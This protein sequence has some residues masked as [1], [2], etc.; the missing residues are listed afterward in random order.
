MAAL[1]DT[2]Q[3]A[4]IRLLDRVDSIE[5]AQRQRLNPSSQPHDYG[6]DKTPSDIKSEYDFDVIDNGTT[7]TLDAAVAAVASV[8]P[9]APHRPEAP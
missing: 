4:M 6:L 2:L 5:A 7:A 1:L 3:H 9:M 8:Q